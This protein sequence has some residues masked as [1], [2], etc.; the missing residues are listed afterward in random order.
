ML[1]IVGTLRAASVS[2]CIVVIRTQHAAS[3]PYSDLAYS[4]IYVSSRL[5]QSLYVVELVQGLERSETVDVQ[6]EE[7]LAD[8]LQDWVVQLE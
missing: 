2:C 5:Y 7:L 6:V 8:V 4:Q 1:G 3:L